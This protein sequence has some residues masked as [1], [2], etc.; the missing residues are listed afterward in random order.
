MYQSYVIDRVSLI[1]QKLAHS[2]VVIN[3]KMLIVT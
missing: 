2:S 1:I 3:Y